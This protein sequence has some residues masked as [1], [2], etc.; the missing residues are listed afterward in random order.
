MTLESGFCLMEALDMVIVFGR[1]MS[2][3]QRVEV[4]VIYN[5][6]FEARF[7]LVDPLKLHLTAAQAL[8][9]N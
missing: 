3:L 2:K 9:N 7:I 5:K 4:N 8:E 6:T 1:K